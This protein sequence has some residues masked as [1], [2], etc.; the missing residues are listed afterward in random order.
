MGTCFIHATCVGDIVEFDE[1]GFEWARALGGKLPWLRAG[2]AFGK[3]W[4]DNFGDDI[5]CFAHDNGVARAHILCGHLIA[6]VEGGHADGGTTNKQRLEHRK[7]RGATGAT[8]RHLDVEQQCVLFLWWELECNRPPWRTRGETKLIALCKIIHL[9]DNAIDFVS[10][11]VATLL[12]RVAKLQHLFDGIH[13]AD[14]WVDR[15]TKFAQ[16]IKCGVMTGELGT[17]DNFT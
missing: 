17:A 11:F 14:F 2:G 1:G 10:E 8:H 6:V 4:A 12:P 16:E 13:D 3:D 9:D 7:R 15:K 5:A